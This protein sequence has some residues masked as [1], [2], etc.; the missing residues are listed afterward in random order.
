[1]ATIKRKDFPL[2]ERKTGE[3]GTPGAAPDEG[4]AEIAHVRFLP[5]EWKSDCINFGS[6]EITRASSLRAR[7]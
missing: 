6:P 3:R 7:G 4:L 2:T 5:N 1:M